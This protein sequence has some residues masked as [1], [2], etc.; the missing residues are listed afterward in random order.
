MPQD[1]ATSESNYR[2]FIERVRES[3]EVWGLR[4]DDGWAYCASNEYEDTDVLVFWSERAEAQR[5]AQGDWAQHQPAVIVLDEFIE[6]WLQGM[7][8]DGAL[9][10][11]NWDPEFGGLEVEPSDMADELTADEE[12]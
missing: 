9:V 12:A 7:D 10:G 8:E 2:R 6:N 1:S 11:P 3:G 4:S 5:H